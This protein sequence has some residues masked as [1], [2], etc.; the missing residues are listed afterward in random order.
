MD[1][2]YSAWIENKLPKA[3]IE[4]ALELAMDVFQDRDAAI[5]WLNEAHLATNN[6]AP[7]ALLGT[8]E[9]FLHLKTL[10]SRIAHGVLA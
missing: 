5:A 8:E 7:I 10:L 9:G 1:F 6:K 3:Q 2:L 4:S